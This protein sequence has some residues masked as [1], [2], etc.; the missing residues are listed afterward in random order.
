MF[1]L[2]KPKPVLTPFLPLYKQVS[3]SIENGLTLTNTGNKFALNT[4]RNYKAGITP[5]IAYQDKHGPI[6]LEHITPKW[7]DQ[8]S[9]FMMNE[10]YCKNTIAVTL[11]RVKAILNR[12]DIPLKIKASIEQTTTV[13]NTIEELHTLMDA[14]L[15]EVPGY[16]RV[17]DIYV[18][19][20][21]IGLRYSD[22]I[23]V[24]NNPLH[25][26]RDVGNKKY[27]E[28]LTTKT[29]TSVVIPMSRTVKQVMEKYY[30]NFGTPFSYQ[31]YNE[32]IKEIAKRAGLTEPVIYSRTEG[33]QRQDTA[34]PKYQLMS[35]HTARRTFATNSFL[36]G[37]SEKDIMQITGHK[38]TA[39]FH[40]YIRSTAMQSA[41]K[42]ASH[43]FF[44]I[45][46]P[47]ALQVGDKV[48]TKLVTNKQ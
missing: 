31:Y 20:C 7:A 2:F 1:N 45:E 18:L 4:I 40:R 38:T 42:I 35:S 48:Q 41:I 29:N 27:I 36:A 6:Y 37:L 32:A 10:G 17:R 8:F 30:Y 34:I 3:D 9:I 24:L 11:S 23:P 15:T 13:Y 26:I 44:N 16:T 21:F 39:S 46:M 28:V 19:Q 47:G 22:L 25:F 5:L 33:G 12:L 14:D 43:E